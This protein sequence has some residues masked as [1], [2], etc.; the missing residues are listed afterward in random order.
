MLRVA[1]HL[2]RF[3]F[4]TFSSFFLFFKSCGDIHSWKWE[5]NTLEI[6]E[7]AFHGIW[8]KS[9][10]RSQEEWKNCDKI[11]SVAIWDYW[12]IMERILKLQRG[13]SWWIFLLHFKS[14]FH[15]LFSSRHF[16]C[17]KN[18]MMIER[19]SFYFSRLDYISLI[20]WWAICF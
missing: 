15:Q 14:F 3:L 1:I 19:W 16:F 9:F 17:R 4:F 2:S 10:S 5:G 13:L 18:Q 6:Y 8:R 11:Y 7:I 20:D 12:R